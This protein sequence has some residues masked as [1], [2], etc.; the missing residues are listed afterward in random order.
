MRPDTLWK[1]S[2]VIGEDGMMY[3]FGGSLEGFETKKLWQYNPNNEYW[4]LLNTDFKVQ[5]RESHTSVFWKN[6]VIIFGGSLVHLIL[7][8]M[9][10]YDT[11][12]NTWTE[13]ILSERLF[14]SNNGYV[15]F[16]D[17]LY[18]FGG[19]YIFNK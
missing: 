14:R 5:A 13:I 17:I 18:L 7:Y 2:F 4:T 11:T 16:G 6:K 9:W 19:I 8:D 12:L 3:L 1:H 15:L 10:S